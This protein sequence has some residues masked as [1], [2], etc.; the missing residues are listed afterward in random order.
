MDNVTPEVR[1]L[2]PAQVEQFITDGFV[3]IDQ[4]FPRALADAALAILWSATGCSPDD[5]CRVTCGHR[6]ATGS[7]RRARADAAGAG[8]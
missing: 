2:T 7:S 1:G 3:R 8:C 5:P 4:A 6:P